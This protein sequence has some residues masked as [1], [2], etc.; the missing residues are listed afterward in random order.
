MAE[1]RISDNILFAGLIG[2]GLGL[3]ITNEKYE[4]EKHYWRRIRAHRKHHIAQG[5]KLLHHG[6]YDLSHHNKIEGELMIEKGA[7]IIQRAEFHGFPR[8]DLYR[9]HPGHIHH[10]KHG[11]IMEPNVGSGHIAHPVHHIIHSHHHTPIQHS[12]AAQFDNTENRIL[13]T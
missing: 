11:H 5:L 3:F 9:L 7:E 12:F 1:E 8:H 6:V 2:I 13:L 10:I 4:H